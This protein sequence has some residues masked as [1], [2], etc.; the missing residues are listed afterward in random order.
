M[1]NNQA[2]KLLDGA[3]ASGLSPVYFLPVNEARLRMRAAFISKDEPEYV[4]HV[5]NNFIPC[6]GYKIGLRIYRPSTEAKLPCIVYFHGGGWVVNDLDTHD[7]VCR[8]LANQVNAVIVAV[9]YRRSPEFKYPAPIEDAYTA[10]EWVFANAKKLNIDDKKI[11]VGGDS[12]GATQATVVC[13]MARDRGTFSIKFQWLA[14]PVTDF[15]FPGTPSYKEMAEGYSTNRDFMM[16]VWNKY[17]P[18]NIDL[19]DSYL[20]PLRSSDF[21]NLP[22]AFIMTANYDPL[23]DEGELYAQKLIEG[24]V[25][26][27]LKRYEDQMHGF[28]MQRKNIDAAVIAFH[29]A[30]NALK[31]GLK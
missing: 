28:I 30:V 29:D 16:W 24:G 1:L 13:L 9:D 26:V 17:L 4:Y 21:T 10:T 3:K 31:E 23:R 27:I 18:E 12:S 25:K 20:C 5:E 14:Y 8:S 11:A 6:P 15:Y 19:N 2:Q 7:A 22:T